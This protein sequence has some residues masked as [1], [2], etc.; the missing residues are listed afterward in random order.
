MAFPG[1]VAIH[2][3]ATCAACAAVLAEQG[4]LVLQVSNPQARPIPGVVLSTLGDGS[5]GA[6]TDGAGKTRIRLAPE[7]RPNNWVSLQVVRAPLD[8]VFISPWDSK[9]RVPPFENESENFAPVVLS[10]RGDRNLLEQSRAVGSI[11]A[12][13]CAGSAW[14]DLKSKSVEAHRRTALI[15]V[16]SVFAL[17]P[18]EVDRALRGLAA[19]SKEPYERG[20][21]ALYQVSYPAATEQLAQ[22]LDARERQLKKVPAGIINAAVFLGQALYEQGKYGDAAE[23]YRK[24][25]NYRPGDSSILNAVGLS[26][27]K[28]SRAAEAEPFLRRALELQQDASR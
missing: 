24:A 8:L 1:R 19:K 28:A 2:V 17:D 14:K 12:R 25:L 10:A 15:Q 13:V 18:A 23:A 5:I 3:L 26:L 22:A 6:P 9:V 16:A 20:M 11:A 21:S 4:I 27:L 7:T